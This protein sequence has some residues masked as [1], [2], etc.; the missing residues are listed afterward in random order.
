[1][2]HEEILFKYLGTRARRFVQQ[3]EGEWN[4]YASPYTNARAG[5]LRRDEIRWR[6]TRLAYRRYERTI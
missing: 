1:M 2:N 3:V 4:Y 5:C 6:L